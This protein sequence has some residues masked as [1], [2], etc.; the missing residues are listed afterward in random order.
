MRYYSGR[1]YLGRNALALAWR[2]GRPGIG[3]VHAMWLAAGILSRWAGGHE[4]RC[5]WLQALIIGKVAAQRHQL[6]AQ[7]N[8]VKITPARVSAVVAAN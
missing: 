4:A 6:M 2:D 8:H 5:Q 1:P 7:R 3:V